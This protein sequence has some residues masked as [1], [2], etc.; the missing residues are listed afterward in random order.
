M[1]DKVMV[2][3][4]GKQVYW[5]PPAELAPFFA[6]F[7]K[8]MPAFSNLFEFALDVV[9]DMANSDSGKDLC[10][11]DTASYKFAR[12]FFTDLFQSLMFMH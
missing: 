8:P 6:Q 5:G 9:D 4:K 11:V 10:T 3:G 12:L 2:L 7:G 1:I